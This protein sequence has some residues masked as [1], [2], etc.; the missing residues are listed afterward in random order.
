M[1]RGRLSCESEGHCCWPRI[2]FWFPT[3]AVQL[4]IVR[5][6]DVFA[7]ARQQRKRFVYC[8][9]TVKLN[10][11][12]YVRPCRCQQFLFYVTEYLTADKF[13]ILWESYLH[14]VFNISSFFSNHQSKTSYL[15]T[16][17][18]WN[19]ERSQN[20]T[21]SW[22]PWNTDTLPGRE[23]RIDSRSIDLFITS[24]GE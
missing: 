11:D 10:R 9:V 5:S 7:T 17:T 19:L 22:Y 24:C 8:V 15:T 2:A 14:S 4:S 23:S 1:C 3:C 6:K 20:K 18:A 13:V 16:N 12:L 21:V